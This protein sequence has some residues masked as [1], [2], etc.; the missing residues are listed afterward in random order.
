VSFSSNVAND[1]YSG[2][3]NGIPTARD[4]YEVGQDIN[5]AVNLIQGTGYARNSEVDPLFV[6]P[7]YAWRELNGTVMLIGVSAGYSNT[8]GVYTDIGV[9]AVQT[10][11]LG[12]FSGFGF[13]GDGTAANPF[14]AAAT[15][16]GTGSLFGWYLNA[17]GVTDYYSESTLNPSGLDHL[18]TFDLPNANGKTIYIDTGAGATPVTLNDPYLLAWEDLDWDG[19]TLGDEDYNDMIYLV[20]KVSPVTSQQVVLGFQDDVPVNISIKKNLFGKEYVHTD[21]NGTMPVAT[22]DSAFAAEVLQR[23][24]DI[25]SDADVTNISFSDSPSADATTIYFSDTGPAMSGFKT[26]SGIAYTGVDQFNQNLWGQAVV[27]VN[28]G[29][30]EDVAET[31]AH[32]LGHLLGLRHVSPL[33]VAE[34]MEQGKHDS[35]DE[36][37]NNAVSSISD[38]SDSSMTHNP[39]YH[40][41]SYVSGDSHDELAAAGISNGTW[42]VGSA[43]PLTASLDFDPSVYD[44]LLYDLYVFE[45]AADDCLVTLEHFPEISLGELSDE[46]F[47][48]NVGSTL[49]LVGS[50][51]LG[52]ELDTVL[53]LGSPYD[54]TTQF[55]QPIE[56]EITGWLQTY[57]ATELMG[58]VT[59]AEVRIAGQVIPEP[60]TLV[61][62]SALAA[63]GITVRW[64]RGR[65]GAR[66]LRDRLSAA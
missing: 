15:S 22:F 45:G 26:L 24:E 53:A 12:P 42:D 47:L 6:E 59:L 61:T 65:R 64:L 66:Y 34:I 41:R 18:M 13:A 33:G 60:S 28:N 3:V 43:P 11:L 46:S 52:G 49:Q 48:L 19:S 63:L 57:S 10:P 36:Q 27:F 5:D 35:D 56:G 29:D 21:W 55:I 20:D 32:E 14:P 37:F 25:Y 54:P 16:L 23:V 8:T 62:W 1:V 31:A 38:P 40:L 7:D 2:V 9:G 30:R 50:S 44:L 17:N 58:Y 39:V 4:N 51:S